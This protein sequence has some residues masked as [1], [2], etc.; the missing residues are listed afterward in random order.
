MAHDELNGHAHEAPT[1][2]VDES[3][4]SKAN[5]WLAEN[6][7]EI[8][9]QRAIDRGELPQDA[10]RE[11]EEGPELLDGDLVTDAG[12]LVRMAVERERKLIA[13]APPESE[14]SFT[15]DGPP[16]Q[17]QEESEADVLARRRAWL[18]ESGSADI[19]ADAAEYAHEAL[20][21]VAIGM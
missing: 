18:V 20:A 19:L 4:V 3:E 8:E 10:P 1:D 5:R 13:S 11:A 21:D 14:T 7:R 16:G 9:K 15:P 17:V 12:E 2:D 6:Q